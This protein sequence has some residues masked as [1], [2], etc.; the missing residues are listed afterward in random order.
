MTVSELIECLNFYDKDTLV[1]MSKDSE[2]N[3][4]NNVRTVCPTYYIPE[5][6]EAIHDEDLDEYREEYHNIKQV[7]CLW[8]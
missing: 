7:V 1:I 5:T 6:K 2:G 8:P 4:Y 3:N